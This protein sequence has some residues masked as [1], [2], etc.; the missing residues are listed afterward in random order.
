M[1]ASAKGTLDIR[2]F[3]GGGAGT[4]RAGKASTTK[5]K[6]KNK[7]RSAKIGN[8]RATQKIVEKTNGGGNADDAPSVDVD[9][10]DLTL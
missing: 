7:G 5:K 10:V 1:G 3:F 8:K 2:G 6:L 4:G 9:V